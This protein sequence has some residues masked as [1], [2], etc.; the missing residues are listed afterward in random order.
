MDPLEE[1]KQFFQ[2]CTQ[3]DSILETLAT[4]REKIE[5]TKTSVLVDNFFSILLAHARINEAKKRLLK[6]AE[7]Q[8]QKEAL[9]GNNASV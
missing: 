8:K 5:R 1:D 9:K 6:L 3:L 7:D 2:V 4:M